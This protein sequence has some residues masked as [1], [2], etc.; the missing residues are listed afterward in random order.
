MERAATVSAK[1]SPANK[2]YP[3]LANGGN[4]LG[5]SSDMFFL[6]DLGIG[7]VVLTNMRVAN[8][9]LGA[10]RQKL[11]E[12]L[13]EADHSSDAMIAAALISLDKSTERLATTVHMDAASSTWIGS[14]A[15]DYYSEELGAARI[16]GEPNGTY[17]IEFDSWSSALGTGQPDELV[18]TSPPWRGGFRLHVD[19]QAQTLVS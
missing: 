10:F 9:F 6:P 18:L 2:G 17:V 11:L 8:A 4:T 14:H 19:E 5:F 12:V 16:I 1:P 13:F 15:G 3:P 7:V